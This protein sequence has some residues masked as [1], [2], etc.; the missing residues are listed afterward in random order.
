MEAPAIAAPVVESAT[1]P[2]ICPVEPASTLV[3]WP[4]TNPKTTATPTTP[5]TIDR[6]FIGHAPHIG[7]RRGGPV[8]SVAS[9]DFARRGRLDVA[10][11]VWTL[12]TAVEQ[13]R[14][15]TAFPHRLLQVR[16]VRGGGISSTNNGVH[17]AA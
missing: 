2:V 14:T 6:K 8:Q 11:H 10:E 3:S 12:V 5:R 17:Q 4:N 15:G 9:R 7:P 13:K 16:A 1:L